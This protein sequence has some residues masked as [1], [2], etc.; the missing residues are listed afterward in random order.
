M[1]DTMEWT[2][3]DKSSWPDG[4]WQNEPDKAQW[5]DK[6]TGYDCLIVRNHSGA[7][8]G[9]VGVPEGHPCHGK[10][11]DD[12]DVDVHGGL[13]F[14][15]SCN[16]PTREKWER[17]RESMVARRGEIERHPRG[18]AA[19]AWAETGRYVD[20]FDGWREYAVGRAI[21]HVPLAGR[22]D[23]VWWLGF[24]CSHYMDLSPAY[25]SFLNNHSED[26]YR[27][28]LYVEIQV[29]KLA[30]QLKALAA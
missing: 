7:W 3:I 16:E 12:V 23:K 25:A 19:Q 27:D 1:T 4:P 5:I 2:R 8:C 28:R 30:S 6:A 24:D 26:I 20:D 9:Y 22:P 18:D 17:W 11:Y 13:T 15:D 29:R 10:G 21:C 14:A